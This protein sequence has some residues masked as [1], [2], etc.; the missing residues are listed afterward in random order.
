MLYS[1][2]IRMKKKMA[3]KKMRFYKVLIILFSALVLFSKASFAESYK[4]NL[5]IGV[6]Q[7][8]ATFHPAIDSMQAKSYVL[9]AVRRP[10]TVYDEN[11]ELICMLCTEVPTPDNGRVLYDKNDKGEDIVMATFTLPKEAVWGDGKPV[12]T[13][14]VYFTWQVGKHPLS[15]FSNNQLFAKDIADIR[16]IDDKNFTVVFSKQ[17]CGYNQLNDFTILPAHLEKEVFDTDPATYKDRTLY[18]KD[19]TNPGLYI[20]P[21]VI[22]DV[23]RGQFVTL[24]KNPYWWGKEAYFDTIKIR[25]IE[26]TASL[27]AALLS[28]DIDY[29]AGELG[30]SIDQAFVLEKRLEGKNFSFN[31]VPG[32]IYEHAEFNLDVPHLSEKDV[33]HALMYGTNRQAMVDVLF[34]NKQE[35]AHSFVHP[36]DKFYDDAVKRYAFDPE[37]ASTL[38]EQAGWILKE[39]GFRYH[40]DTNK[41]LRIVLQT[42]AGNKSREIIE[43]VIQSDWNRLGVETVIKN[44]PPRIFFG[45]SLRERSFPGMAMFAFLSAPENVPRTTL[46][47]SMIPNAENGYAGQNFTGFNN[48]TMDDA[49]DKL[50]TVCEESE[51]TKLWK[52]LQ[53]IYAEELPSLPLFFKSDAYFTPS[54]LHGIK[55]TGHQYGTTLWIENWYAEKP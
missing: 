17:T 21:Y 44:E 9:G 25:S 20:G 36:M 4:T 8:P 32:L 24:K 14:D 34:K 45:K 51:R 52:T 47:S 16:I 12:T 30:L 43:Q 48:T 26:N 50:E 23:K 2:R 29:I 49:I 37:K 1:N 33:R 39:D 38:L 55:P 7:F 22:A 11:W 35:L 31:Y 5:T 15:G 53:D 40:K 28:G 18:N 27:T 10:I 41:R 46:H 54:W 3:K 19:T 13:E 42:T 6:S